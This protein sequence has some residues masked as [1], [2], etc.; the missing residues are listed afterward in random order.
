MTG[1]KHPLPDP[2]NAVTL[3]D[4]VARLRQLKAWAKDMS[5]GAITRL[6]NDDWA[7]NGRPRSERTTRSTV[8]G[9]FTFG[10]SRLD[11]ELLVAIVSALH[12]QPEYTQRWR[13]ALHVIRGNAAAAA[14]VDTRSELPQAPQGFT[15]RHDELSCLVE[16]VNNH[17]TVVVY[18][19][20]G[21][22][23]T[24]LALHAAHRLAV[25]RGLR[26]TA[27]LRGFGGVATPA[28]P[29]AVLAGF[30]R[31]LGMRHEQIP[32]HLSE[33][34]HSYRELTGAGRALVL[35]DDAVDEENVAPLLPGGDARAIITSRRPL[36]GLRDAAHLHL[37]APDRD[38]SLDLLRQAAGG[39]R[40]D[41]DLAGANRVVE[42]V[43]RH[44][45]ALSVIGEHMRHHP[46]WTMADYAQPIGLALDGG[47]RAA[48]A[49]CLDRLPAATRRVWRLLALHPGYEVSARAVAALADLTP[50]TAHGHLSALHEAQLV[51]QLAADRYTPHEL[52]RGYAIESMSLEEPAS[53]V[54]AAQR[55]LYDYYRRSAA[56]AV[57]RIKP[58][59]A[60]GSPQYDEACRWLAHEHEN[61][62]LITA[63]AAVRG[64]PRVERE[65]AA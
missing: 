56:D 44:P 30:L 43:G 1:T 35:L 58:D 4:L 15:G 3:D 20:A 6:V 46:D 24:W 5:Y 17:R 45:L 64:W 27:C 52:V 18:G 49:D 19:M 42:A 11:E 48:L 14:L 50:D 23:K 25:N 60:A 33:Q 65:V 47:V 37:V 40:V 36:P 12:P 31:H 34:V 26:L 55:R 41:R 7:R 61:L 59:D 39:H 9:Y 53:L 21:I 38:S 8:A 51:R 57:A 10:R 32:R 29:S 22:G 63:D 16:L 28:S 62:L 54:R 13:H 2:S